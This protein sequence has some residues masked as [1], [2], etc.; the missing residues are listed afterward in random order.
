MIYPILL[1]LVAPYAYGTGIR[2]DPGEYATDEE[3]N[4]WINGYDSGFAGKY[5]KDRATDCIEHD[6]NYNQMWAFGCEES[7]RTEAECG[8]LIN[9]PVEIDDF[10]ALKSATLPLIRWHIF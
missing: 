5:D 8:D 3:A 9:S 1:L 2:H 7:L 10:E 4:C 6:D